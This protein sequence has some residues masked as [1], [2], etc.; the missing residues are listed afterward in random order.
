[1]IHKSLKRLLEESIL[2]HRQQKGDCLSCSIQ[3]KCFLQYLK[4]K[5]Q[6]LPSN[7]RVIWKSSYGDYFNE[8]LE[9]LEEK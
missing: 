2:I 7:E 1:M 9:V 4:I 3:P 5:W 6:T 8:L